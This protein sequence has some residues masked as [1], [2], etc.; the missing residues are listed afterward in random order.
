MRTLPNSA[1]LCLAAA[2]APGCGSKF[3]PYSHI[4]ALSVVAIKAEPPELGPGQTAQLTAEA[5]DPSGND[6]TIQWDACFDPPSPTGDVVNPDCVTNATADYLV[7]FGEGKSVSFTMPKIDPRLLGL[8]DFTSGLYLPL[9]LTV[10]AGDHQ[11]TAVYRMRYSIFPPPNQNPRIDGLLLLP[12][13]VTGAPGGS[14]DDGTVF[15]AG[16]AVSFRAL[17]HEGGAEQYMVVSLDKNKM[18]VFSP[19]TEE[20]RVSW[21]STVG[22]FDNEHTG[23]AR[24]DTTLTIDAGTPPGRFDL[25]AAVSDGRG[26]E[27]FVHRSLVVR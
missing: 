15:E 9:R 14:L 20:L 19:Q 22:T 17:L 7:P 12:D 26:G 5:V 11:I 1:L 25:F 13:G 8:P 4:A 24:P 2:A 16:R 3:Q 27:D 6:I 21:F 18:P 23:V 10:S